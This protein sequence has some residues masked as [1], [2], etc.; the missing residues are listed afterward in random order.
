MLKLNNL[1]IKFGGLTAV[2]NITVEIEKHSISSII[3]PNG[4]GK[5]TLFNMIGGV[6][7]PQSGTII[8]EGKQIQG[9]KPYQISEIGISRT[10]QNIN[11][12]G[13]MSVL[14]N[15]KV[16]C[17]TIIDYGLLQAIFR[18][19]KQKEQEQKVLDKSKS[20]LA[21][22]GLDNKSS[23]QAKH[24]PYGE[25]RLVEIAR[26]I[27]NEPDIVLLDEPAA[28]MNSKEKNDLIKLIYRI[29]DMGITILLVEHD[30]KVVMGISDF[31]FVMNYG[32]EIARGVPNYVQQHPEVITAYLGVDNG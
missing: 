32:K 4:A 15:I 26:A 31:V 19:K 30:M 3:G 18:T 5:T 16:G 20:L 8:F 17:H 6:C 11:L 2:D 9:M 7:K 28:G 23:V 24:L 27:S 22:I 29:R 14:D 12:F 1:T 25:Q 10:Y 21:F 13:S